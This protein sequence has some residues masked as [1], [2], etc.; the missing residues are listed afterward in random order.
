MSR[1]ILH[2][3]G[4]SFFASC[5]VAL[6]PKL[7]GKPVVTGH[8]RGIATAMSKEAKA[9]G[10]HRGMPVFMI[11]RLY[12][13]AIVV[14]SQYHVYGMF[15]QR[16]Y[17]IVR[18]YTDMVEEYSI[19]ECFA[20]ITHLER[21]GV[22]HRDI[23]ESIRR[24]LKKELGMTFSIGL[25]ETKVLAKVASKWEKPDGLTIID[26]ANIEDILHKLP[27]G[28]VWGIGPS[29]SIELNRHGIR[30][31]HDFVSRP[32][33]YIEANFS[34]PVV[35]TWH[36]LRG[37]KIY[38]VHSSTD[39]TS[40]QKSVQSTKSF[41]KVSNDRDFILSELSRNVERVSAHARQLRLIGK[42]VYIFLKTKEFRYKR[43]DVLL[44][45]AT[46]SPTLIMNEVLK[47]FDGIYEEESLYRST[48]VTLANLVPEGHI[49]EDLFGES[50][51]KDVWKKIFEITDNIDRRYGSTTM[52]LASSLSAMRV[53]GYKPRRLL[54]IPSMGET[55]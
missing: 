45:Q 10:I 37:T 7:K 40:D 2:I 4:D 12:P 44:T 23:A 30:T 5:E 29:T 54:N 13:T 21:P 36:E 47:I 48:G 18:R 22:T 34:R 35:E 49:Q 32:K 24:E 27:I 43:A 11:R 8:E 53:R 1:A 16:M 55:L 38:D 41:A 51:K 42:H 20:D 9:L 26:T 14:G 25:G 6:N 3:D 28:A 15:A 52:A 17:D 33:S 50:K 19:D 31:A 39:S 46:S